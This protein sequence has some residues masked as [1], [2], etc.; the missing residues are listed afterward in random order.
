MKYNILH[1]TRYE[2][3]EDASLSHNELFLIPRN[4]PHQ[5]CIENTLTLFP[6]PSVISRRT[7]YFG[8]TVSA[9]TIQTPHK[10]LEISAVSQVDLFPVNPIQPDQTPAWDK[11]KQTLE[12]HSNPH[13][14]DAFQFV[15]A[16]PL[17]PVAER[18]AAWARDLF[19][20]GTPIL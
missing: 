18:F 10:T 15:F 9:T 2:Y 14:L 7:D 16:S 8:N 5:A 3:E 12:Q 1:T 20:P 13:D 6:S 17:V 11:V 4:T 19:A